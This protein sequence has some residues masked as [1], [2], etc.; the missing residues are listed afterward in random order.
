MDR[1]AGTDAGG[2]G[3]AVAVA[4]AVAPDE[5]AF[6]L[7]QALHSSRMTGLSCV[8]AHLQEGGLGPGELVVIHGE[9]ASAKSALLQRIL[10]T[11]IAPAFCGGHE[12]AAVLLDTDGSF[13][14]ASLA[15]VLSARLRAVRAAPCAAAAGAALEKAPAF[16]AGGSLDAAMSRLSVLRPRE[17]MNL[18]RQLHRLHA[19]MAANPALSLLAVDSMSAWQSLAAPFPR[20]VAPVLRECWAAISRLQR[21]HCL[22]V[23]VT[24]RDQPS[25]ESVNARAAGLHGPDQ[26][27]AGDAS[28]ICHLGVARSLPQRICSEAFELSAWGKVSGGPPVAFAFNSV[29]EIVSVCA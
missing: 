11:C 18:L 10:A 14:A 20:T 26:G 8:D 13:D 5:T 19:K 21:E 28:R 4:L 1:A 27:S 3:G 6:E 23:V 22:A 25:S 16:E 24:H 29:G 2:A 15:Q 7:V 12:R 9:A 17:P